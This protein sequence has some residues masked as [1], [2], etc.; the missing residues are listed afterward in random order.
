MVLEELHHRV[1]GVGGHERVALLADVA[2]LEEHAD[3]RGVGRRASDPLALEPLH[4]ARLRIARGWLRLV[5]DALE[6]GDH[7]LLSLGEVREERLLVVERGFGVVLALDVDANVAGKEDPRAGGGEDR[8]AH[9]N[10]RGDRRLARVGHLARQRSF[11]DELVERLLTPLEPGLVRVDEALARRTDR[12]VRLLG[13]AAAGG[14]LPR[15]GEVLVP[16]ELLYARPRAGEAFLRKRRRVGSHVGNEPLLVE[17]LRG[18][19][20]LAGREAQLPVS[21]LLQARRDEGGRRP[22]GELLLGQRRDAPRLRFELGGELL[23]ALLVDHHDIAVGEQTPVE[24]VEVLAARDAFALHRFEARLEGG[25]RGV[26]F[27]PEACPEVPVDRLAERDALAL[28][29]DDEAQAR[30][31]HA[32][33]GQP[34]GDLLPDERRERVAVEPV[35][36]AP[37][38]LRVYEVHVYVALVLERVLDRRAGDLVEDHASHRDLR[39]QDVHEVPRDALTLA[40]LVGGEQ[41]LIGLLE[42]VLQLPHDLGLVS[43]CDVER[44]EIVVDVDAE[45]GPV[46]FLELLGNV[47]GALGKVPDVTDARLHVV[48]RSEEALDGAGLGRRLDDDKF[49]CCHI[50]S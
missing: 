5:I 34:V 13:L 50:P 15:F 47:G 11:P 23:R 44:G 29:L 17:T 25:R 30:R 42:A 3:D 39:L 7:E 28:S 22:R 26:L 9:G 19:H 14:E 33:G 48:F 41:D 46:E 37:G 10:L 38:L 20:R 32:S 12:L 49:L 45:P 8:L 43:R 21:L 27:A 16:V 18:A 4:E 24:G 6:R 31:L 40:V 36:D 1:P 35:E 2:A